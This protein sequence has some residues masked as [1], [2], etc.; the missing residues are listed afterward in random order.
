MS[1]IQKPRT[2]VE[3]IQDGWYITEYEAG[4]T[5]PYDAIGPYP[6]ALRALD[7]AP[8]AILVLRYDQ[9]GAEVV[10]SIKPGGSI[11]EES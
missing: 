10:I 3:Y 7:L 1:D 8:E 6:N 5:S 11:E 9:R 2:K 4:A